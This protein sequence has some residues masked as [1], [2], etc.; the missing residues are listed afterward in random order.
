MPK[1][2]ATPGRIRPGKVLSRFHERIV[3]KF[4]MTS[5]SPGIIIVAIMMRKM[6][7][8]PRNGMNTTA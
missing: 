4:E 2:E 6:I 5:T 1:V 3:W 7:F 8:L